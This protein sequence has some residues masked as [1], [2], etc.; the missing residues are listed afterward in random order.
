[1]PPVSF[2][3][4]Q[5]HHH[6]ARLVV[7]AMGTLNETCADCGGSMIEVKSIAIHSSE[8]PITFLTWC[9]TCGAYSRLNQE[10]PLEWY[11]RLLANV[12]TNLRLAD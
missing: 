6:H 5:L 11:R 7:N 9:A 1:M 10:F 3:G 8:S 4:I 2:D 12:G